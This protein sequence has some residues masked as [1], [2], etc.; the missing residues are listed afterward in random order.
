MLIQPQRYIEFPADRVTARLPKGNVKALRRGTQLLPQLSCARIGALCFRRGEALT[1]LNTVAKAL[2]NS[3][4]RRWRSGCRVTAP[5]GPTPFGI[6]RPLPPS[7]SG[8]PSHDR[9]CPNRRLI[10]QR[11]QPPR[12]GARRFGAG[13]PSVRATGFRALRR[14]AHAVAGESRVTGCCEPRPA[15]ARA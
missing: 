6:A 2:Q 11:A 14:F 8:R 13:S 5:A 3:S 9:P 10:F 7:P 12:N 15:P 4:S 1:V